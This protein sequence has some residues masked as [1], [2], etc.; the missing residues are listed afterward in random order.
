M[1]VRATNAEVRGIIE[2]DPNVSMDPFI[3]AA[4]KLTD[5]IS[6]FATDNARTVTA[7][8]LAVIETWLAAHFYAH[9]DQLYTQRSTGKA[10]GSFQG[11]T[12]MGLD[13]TQYGQTAKLLDP[14]GY[15]RAFDKGGFA[16][17][18]WGGTEEDADEES[19]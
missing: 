1:A 8:E 6:I 13:S 14:T 19:A 10:S 16:S 15:L 2:T 11:K 18:F 17:M 5:R 4:N 12:A 3:K 7:A 9:R